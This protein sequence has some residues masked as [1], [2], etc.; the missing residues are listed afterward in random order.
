[1]RK[2]TQQNTLTDYGDNDNYDDDRHY[3]GNNN[4]VIVIILIAV[5]VLSVLFVDGCRWY[6]CCRCCL[7]RRCLC[8]GCLCRRYRRWF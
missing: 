1:M 6:F 7:Y 8:R 5:I 2:F 4:D 3:D